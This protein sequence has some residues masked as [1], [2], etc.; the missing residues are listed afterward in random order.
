MNISIVGTGYVGLTTGVLLALAGNKVF[1]IDVDKK[2]LEIIKSGKSFF[3]EP[4]LDS[5]VKKAINNKKLIPTL[6]YEE[7]I[8]ESDVVIIAVGTPSNPDGSVDLSFIFSALESIAKNMTKKII[9]VQKST[10]PVGTGR[11]IEEFFK[12][13]D[14]EVDVVSCPEFLSEGSAVIDSINMDRF[15]VGGD[16]DNAKQKIAKLFQ[17]ID[18][19]NKE[20]D[21]EDYLEYASI[22]KKKH[23]L[24]FETP[25][26]DRVI[27][28]DLESAEMVKVTANAFLAMKIS[29]ANSI[30]RICDRSG[31][32]INQVMDGIGMDH[33]INRAFLYAGLGWGGGCFPKDTAGLIKFADENGFDFNILKAVVE[34]N[35][36]QINF[37][38][39]KA[40]DILNHNLNGKT[41]A[42][43]GLAFKPGTSDIRSSLSIKLVQNLLQFNAKLRVIDPKAQEGARSML[44][45]TVHYGK[46]I[47]DTLKDAELI[48]LA[49]EWPEFVELD[50]SRYRNILKSNKILDARNKLDKKK[51]VKQGFEYYGIGR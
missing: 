24:F 11:K 29:F 23:Q 48:I 46:N 9:V 39:Q 33:R 15:I 37:V 19:L 47:E 13:R 35:S 44:G 51:L 12:S 17:G 49:T 43:L 21:I 20:L 6:S 1:C 27:F 8:P 4:G 2:K 16:S 25:F 18:E 5:L 26:K 3:Y 10:V 7:S 40:K 30:A 42:V 28:M 31:A 36:D 45:D 34:S 14:K 38:T 50:F 32:D 41:I 22:Y